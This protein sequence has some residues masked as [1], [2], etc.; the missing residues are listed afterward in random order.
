MVATSRAALSGVRSAELTTGRADR[1]PS[2]TRRRNGHHR[3]LRLIV[4]LSPLVGGLLLWQALGSDD[5]FTFPRP[6]SWFDAARTMWQSGELGPA[7]RQTLTTFALGTG[8]AIVI[9]AA[10]GWTIGALRSADRSLSPSLEFL[11]AAP[12][13]AL[14]P[15]ATV[16]LGVSTLMSVVV[17][18]TAVVWPVLL[19][20]ASARREIPPVRLDAGRVLGLSRWHRIRK[21]EFPSL[22]PGIMTG[23]RVTT[24]LG[25]VV[26]LVLDIIGSGSGIGRLLVIKQQSFESPSVWAILV[27]IGLFGLAANSLVAVAEERVRRGWS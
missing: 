1:R 19:S 22:L 20:T 10:L 4:G 5:A 17:M 2:P 27:V 24:S 21:I 12:A 7:L 16:L 13:P 8:V 9:G 25:F 11:R 14:V 15:V 3:G 23:V 6:S 26:S 18:V